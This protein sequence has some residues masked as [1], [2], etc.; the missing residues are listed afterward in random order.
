[1]RGAQQIRPHTIDPGSQCDLS[2]PAL[3]ASVPGACGLTIRRKH[4][5]KRSL[6]LAAVRCGS[7]RANLVAALGGIN[8]VDVPNESCRGPPKWQWLGPLGQPPQLL[9]NALRPIADE[10]H[11]HGVHVRRRGAKMQDWW[12]VPCKG[13]RTPW[14]GCRRRVVRA[15]LPRL[16]LPG[17]SPRPRASNA[18]NC[19]CER[20]R[21][22]AHLGRILDPPPD[23][24]PIFPTPLLDP[25]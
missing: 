9:C 17:L 2:V 7:P 8:R 10:M 4:G 19:A 25:P 6:D 1:M 20:R 16:S 11:P 3:P 21:C 22:E 13:M 18:G 23:L 12:R 24:R 14:K 15:A 5:V